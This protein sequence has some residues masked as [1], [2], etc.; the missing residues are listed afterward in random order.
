MVGRL[1]QSGHEVWIVISV[2][3]VVS[4][5]SSIHV[6]DKSALMRDDAPCDC[7]GCT[8]EGE[9]PGG[10]V[11][12]ALELNGFPKD[13]MPAH[14][15]RHCYGDATGPFRIY[16]DQIV[17]KEICGYPIRFET[18]IS[19]TIENGWIRKLQGIRVRPL[20]TWKAVDTLQ[21]GASCYGR[22]YFYVGYLFRSFLAT[23]FDGIWSLDDEEENGD[24]EGCSDEDGSF[25]L[26]G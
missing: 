22:V 1:R 25:R 23:E 17:E 20:I 16:L 4:D 3:M 18:E 24:K 13:L 6:P 9:T 11:A 5:L 14:H 15:I 21:T 10:L 2:D 7:A 8:R 26:E 12:K 19:G